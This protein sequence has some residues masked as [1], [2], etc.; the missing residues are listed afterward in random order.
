MEAYGIVKGY[1]DNTFRP[2]DN[3]TKAQAAEMLYQVFKSRQKVQR[4]QSVF[5][6]VFY[7]TV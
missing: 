1:E 7:G 6:A 2:Y 4:T 5:N 3:I